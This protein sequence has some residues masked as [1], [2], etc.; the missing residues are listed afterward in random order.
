MA[1]K[2]VTCNGEVGEA[3]IPV[4]R[5]SGNFFQSEVTWKAMDNSARHGTHYMLDQGSNY[6]E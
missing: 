3:S 6:K 2:E 5:K 4:N 1:T